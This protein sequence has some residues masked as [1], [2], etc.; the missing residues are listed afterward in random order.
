M[1]IKEDLLSKMT[2]EELVQTIESVR[3][4]GVTENA[5]A[6]GM[7][8][9]QEAAKRKDTTNQS[10]IEFQNYIVELILKKNKS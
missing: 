8:I 1:S 7:M 2:D 6:I 9:I 5:E 4:L 10:L 3:K